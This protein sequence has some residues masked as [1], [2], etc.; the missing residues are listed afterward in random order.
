ML[1]ILGHAAGQKGLRCEMYAALLQYLQFCKGS[2]LGDT[3]PLVLE[4]LLEGLGPGTPPHLHF[5]CCFLCCFLGGGSMEPMS[6]MLNLLLRHGLPHS[7][8]D[9][10]MVAAAVCTALS[11]RVRHMEGAY[12]QLCCVV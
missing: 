6:S 7:C 8:G 9:C 1:D 10:V 5:D 11:L 12:L 3:M 4:K 2:K